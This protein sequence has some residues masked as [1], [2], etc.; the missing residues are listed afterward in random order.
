MKAILVIVALVAAALAQTEKP[1]AK[2]REPGFM[3]FIEFKYLDGERLER[4]SN[5]VRQ[6]YLGKAMIVHAPTPKTMAIRADTEADM[7]AV[8]A[9]FRKFDV[10]QAESRTR[11]IDVLVYLLE[12]TDQAPPPGQE[13]PAELSSTAVQ[14]R[15]LFGHKHLRLAETILMPGRHG[16]KFSSSGMLAMGSNQPTYYEAK[17]SDVAYNETEKSVSINN[18][19]FTLRINNMPIS[20]VESNITIKEGQKLVIGKV[21]KDPNAPGAFLVVTAKVN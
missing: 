8:E 12:P 5:F 21:N 19:G 2:P 4:V 10:P 1:Q 20:T 6:L 15:N 18:L 14:L 13:V 7:D 3:K 11:Q 17:Y 16:G 9:M